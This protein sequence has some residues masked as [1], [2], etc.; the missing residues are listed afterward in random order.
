MQYT[1]IMS[2]SLTNNKSLVNAIGW[3]GVLAILFAYAL[4][5]LGV[6][7]INSLAYLGLNATG[8]VAIVFEAANK[9]DLPVIALNTVWAL[10][11][12]CGILKFFI[13][14]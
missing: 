5:N 1:H 8:S 14:L 9:R 2:K 3:Y 11:A 10:I 6:I 4:S 12:F 13:T 7:T